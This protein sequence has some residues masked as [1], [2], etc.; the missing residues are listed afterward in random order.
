VAEAAVRLGLDE[1]EARGLV[2]PPR[3]DE[4]VV[5]PQAELVVSRLAGE[6]NNMLVA[7]GSTSERILHAAI[8]EFAEHGSSGARVARIADAG[9]EP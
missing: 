9:R 4:R 7:N 2:D 8:E 1:R 3:R 5:G 6:P